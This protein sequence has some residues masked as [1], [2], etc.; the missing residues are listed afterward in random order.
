MA[1]Y[2]SVYTGA[3]VDA[4]VARTEDIS[5]FVQVYSGSPVNTGINMSSIP[6]DPS[7]G[8]KTGLYDIVYSDTTVDVDGSTGN[9]YISRLYIGD[10]E[11]RS[12]GSSVAEIQVLSDTMYTTNVDYNID[13]FSLFTV[14]YKTYD[15]AANTGENVAW[16]IHKI[17]R[18]QAKQ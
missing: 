15:M 1:N 8:L 4:A 2:N 13:G 14:N 17:Y 3:E 9:A 12:H 18:L 16:Y 10:I 7:T 6:V 5:E 11:Q